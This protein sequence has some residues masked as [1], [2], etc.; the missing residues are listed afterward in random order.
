M[1]RSYVRIG[2]LIET[3]GCNRM[4]THSVAHT[5]LLT[6]PY[7]ERSD[8]R[9]R[10]S[11]LQA[12]RN[13]CS[14]RTATPDSRPLPPNEEVSVFMLSRSRKRCESIFVLIVLH[15]N[16]NQSCA[17]TGVPNRDVSHTQLHVSTIKRFS[18]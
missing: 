9:L 2:E 10:Y 14:R 7:L 15:P 17:R 5:G 4:C 6:I 3:R 13:S 12:S 18:P 16:D 8:L 11:R 1:F